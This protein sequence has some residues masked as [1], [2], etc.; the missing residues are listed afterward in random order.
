MNF[1]LILSFF[2]TF[3]FSQNIIHDKIERSIFFY[4]SYDN[5]TS[6][7]IG[8]QN[9]NGQTNKYF[10]GSIWLSDNLAISSS[11]S[12]SSID[13]DINLYYNY[14]MAYIPLIFKTN[15]ISA[16]FNFGMHR[17]RFYKNKSSRWY[18]L[19][20]VS[21]FNYNKN[22]IILSWHYFTT[23]KT[24]HIINLAYK[25]LIYKKLNILIESKFYTKNK[26][27]SIQPNLQLIINL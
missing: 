22:K 27:I 11:L 6:L 1:L 23:I 24:K 18:D 25:K 26:K 21:D 14:S 19:S 2:I 15:N 20:I 12:N 17:I 13:S 3:S 5:K 8:C 7:G 10:S 4:N 16:K 9:S